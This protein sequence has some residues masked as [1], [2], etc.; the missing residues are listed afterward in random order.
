MREGL[1]LG[2][3]K[4]V[5]GK[6]ARR[7]DRQ[8]ALITAGTDQKGRELLVASAVEEG[9]RVLDCGAGTGTTG[10]LATRRVGPNGHVTMCD[11]SSEMLEEAR[12]KVTRERLGQ[13]VTFQVGD[14]MQ[15]PFAD[16][17]FDVVLSTYSLCPLYDP[18]RGAMELMRVTRPGGRIGIAH[19]IEP[20]NAIVRWLGRRIESLAWR[21]P[22]LSMGCRPVHVLPALERAGCKLTFQERIGFPLWPFVVFVVI[23][24]TASLG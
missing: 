6:L 11:L 2:K 21:F 4:T 24:P 7:Y 15:L 12:Q 13:R 3:L 14:M 20:P 17:Q 9:D 10:I 1:A 16:G 8:H 22:S 19:S 23:K 18:A 5:Y